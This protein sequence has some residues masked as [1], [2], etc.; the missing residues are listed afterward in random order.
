[1]TDTTVPTRAA[2]ERLA[3]VSIV[4]QLVRRPDIG[5]AIGA[6]AV[7]CLF[8][9]TARSV[10]WATDLGITAQ[11]ADQAAQYGIVAVAVALLM[12]GGEFD[13]SAGVMVGSSGLLLALLATRTDMN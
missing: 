7:W 5:A 9:W 3:R 2:D 6:V 12:I 1:M 11:W 13:L 4:A 10:H 8:A